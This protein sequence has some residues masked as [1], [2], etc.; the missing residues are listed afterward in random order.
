MSDFDYF[1]DPQVATVEAPQ[2]QVYTRGD[3]QAQEQNDSSV[4]DQSEDVQ[5]ANYQ[6][7]DDQFNAA[8]Y[9]PSEIT[10]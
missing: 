7:F 8:S 3:Y 9:E 4:Q 6:Q 5:Q 1:D 2:Q 10:P